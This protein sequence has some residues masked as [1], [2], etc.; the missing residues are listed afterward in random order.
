MCGGLLHAVLAEGDGGR[1][2]CD[3][4]AVRSVFPDDVTLEVVVD[5]SITNPSETARVH[6][7]ER[8]RRPPS[9]I[10]DLVNQI[11]RRARPR[12]SAIRV[13]CGTRGGCAG[14]Q[15]SG[16]SRGRPCCRLHGVVPP[17]APDAEGRPDV[18]HD[19]VRRR[20]DLPDHR[21]EEPDVSGGGA[22]VRGARR[23]PR[24]G[25][26][27]LGQDL[28]GGVRGAGTHGAGELRPRAHRQVLRR[29]AHAARTVLQVRAFQSHLI[30][31]SVFAKIQS[32]RRVRSSRSRAKAPAKPPIAH[33]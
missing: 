9:R 2:R 20:L 1:H 31:S 33:R 30:S 25:G 17:S 12:K 5:S 3:V 16:T 15:A 32:S 8:D 22:A 14:Q 13:S 4:C 26:L 23:G 6:P 21:A 11:T 19:H 7:S 28:G 18:R 24:G 10:R 29:G 27:D